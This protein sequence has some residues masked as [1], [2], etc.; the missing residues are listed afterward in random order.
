MWAISCTKSVTIDYTKSPNV[1]YRSYSSDTV[2]YAVSVYGINED[3]DENGNPIGLTFGPATG[4]ANN[5]N[6]TYGNYNYAYASHEPTGKTEKGNPHRCIHDDSWDEIIYWASEDPYVYEQCEYMGNR[7]D[8]A[9]DGDGAGILYES[10]STTYTY[11]NGRASKTGSAGGSYNYGGWPASRIRA[12]L[13]GAQEDETADGV[14]HTLEDGW[15]VAGTDAADWTED[16]SLLAAFPDNIRA[17]IVKKA[18]RSD[19]VYNDAVGNN[20]TSY[21]KLWLFSGAELLGSADEFTDGF[22]TAEYGYRLLR[23][24]EGVGN[25]KDT[26]TYSRQR[27]LSM[28]TSSG[29]KYQMYCYDEDSSHNEFWLRTIS[30]SSDEKE[31]FFTRTSYQDI[32]G[33]WYPYVGLCPGFCI[34]TQTQ[35][36]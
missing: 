17:A 7:W 14:H 9:S 24:N 36:N 33:S 26:A 4:Y 5:K 25:T 16:T 28:K 23:Q 6:N 15:Q 11:W 29:F 35:E 22:G 13:N 3:T 10:L 19:T 8:A 21:D 34:G 1:K 31:F 30:D 18:V 2:K 12:A 32:E 20:K 27:Y